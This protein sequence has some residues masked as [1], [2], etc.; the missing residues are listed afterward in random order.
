MAS[1]CEGTGALCQVSCCPTTPSPDHPSP[2]CEVQLLRSK[3]GEIKITAKLGHFHRP[4]L[5]GPK[6][7]CVTTLFSPE[8]GSYSGL[9]RAKPQATNN[10]RTSKYNHISMYLP[11]SLASAHRKFKI[12]NILKIRTATERASSQLQSDEK[13][14]VPQPASRRRIPHAGTVLR[15]WAETSQHFLAESF[16]KV[17]RAECS[18]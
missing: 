13:A 11:F 12:N 6:Q 5:S 18:L 16:V 4:R 9:H 3:S 1:P 8:R 15:C 10:N 2:K 17:L 14:T 7:H